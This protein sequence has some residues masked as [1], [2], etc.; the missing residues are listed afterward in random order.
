MIFLVNS[1]SNLNRKIASLPFGLEAQGGHRL[2][3][4]HR[5]DDLFPFLSDL[6]LVQLLGLPKQNA[7]LLKPFHDPFLYLIGTVSGYVGDFVGL[8]DR[9]TPSHIEHREEGFRG[10]V[11]LLAV[12]IAGL[13]AAEAIKTGRFKH[14]DHSDSSSSGGDLFLL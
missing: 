4:V 10:R 1:R 8:E 9:A 13:L 11:G 14:I 6:V 7:P 5:G 2:D 12:L 3:F